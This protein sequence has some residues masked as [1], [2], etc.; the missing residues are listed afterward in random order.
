MPPPSRIHFKLALL[1][2][3]GFALL[4]VIHGIGVQIAID[5]A[6]GMQM[7]TGN[8]RVIIVWIVYLHDNGEA[9]LMGLCDLG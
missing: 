1:L 7:N 9:P 3:A 8:Y 5:F 6:P 2:A 4:A